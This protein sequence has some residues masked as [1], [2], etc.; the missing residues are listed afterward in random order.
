MTGTLF[1]T[2]GSSSG[3]EAFDRL[4]GAMVAGSPVR[5]ECEAALQL[6]ID[7]CDPGDRGN[8]FVVGAA[9]EWVVA[10]AA[11]SVGILS[12]PGGHNV[13]GFDLQDLQEAARG[14]WSIKASFQEKAAPFRISNG[15]GGAGRGMTDP[16]V[17]LHPRLP[18]LVLIDPEVHTDVAARVES[19]QD[20]TVLAFR[21]IAD[22][23]VA[24]P[25]CVIEMRVPANE[26][27]GTEDAALLFTKGLLTTERFPR[28]SDIFRASEPRRGGTVVDEIRGLDELR[29]SGALTKEQFDE[30]VKQVLATK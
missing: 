4:R 1:E 30:A 17:F 23:A 25:E 8:R 14:L 12:A 6:L 29:A 24:H 16:T 20:G 3:S 7:R 5:S 22:H 18:G 19:K 9:A 26:H 2:V 11:W 21:P 27:R 13:D 15:L 28:L 10:S